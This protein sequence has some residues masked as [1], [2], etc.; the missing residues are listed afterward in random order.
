MKYFLLLTGL[1]EKIKQNLFYI[2]CVRF[3]WLKKKKERKNRENQ[4]KATEDQKLGL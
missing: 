2:K 3:P 4:Y 1:P